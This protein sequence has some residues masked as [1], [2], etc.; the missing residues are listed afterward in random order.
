MTDPAKVAWRLLA[1]S[2]SAS[3]GLPALCARC[4][5]KSPLIPVADVI[6]PNFTGWDYLDPAL[7]GMCAACA[8]AHLAPDARRYPMLIT[9]D[10]AIWV[11]EAALAI[12]LAEPLGPHAAATVPITSRKHLL[13]AVGWGQVATDDGI[14]TWDA[15]AAGLTKAMVAC[16]ASGAGEKA[17]AYDAVPPMKTLTSV[18]DPGEL[19]TLWEQ[20]GPWAGTPHRRLLA[21]VAAAAHQ[22][23]QR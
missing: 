14:V 23:G 17:L 7:P 19:L 11:D 15:A 8:W 3:G 9:T 10:S 20:L 4:R 6:S 2:D 1:P 5:E 21:K 18:P 22:G 12:R 13:P 16:A